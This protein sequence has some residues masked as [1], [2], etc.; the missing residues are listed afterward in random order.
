MTACSVAAFPAQVVPSIQDLLLDGVVDAEWNDAATFFTTTYSTSTCEPE[1]GYPLKI[2]VKHDNK[3]LYI[4]ILETRI[5]SW[6]PMA[7]MCFDVQDRN[8]LYSK[9]DDS[10]VLPI[11][12]GA[13][14]SDIDRGYYKDGL[15]P[16]RTAG[17]WQAYGSPPKKDTSLG[18]TNDKWG[19]AR[20]SENGYTFEM[21]IDMASGDHN[22][23]S[24]LQLHSGKSIS[25]SFGLMDNRLDSLIVSTI[26][27]KL[28]YLASK[29]T[30]LSIE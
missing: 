6:N 20:V 24:D 3:Y 17:P 27:P 18:G 11:T 8:K 4:A 19:A 12:G 7:W 22:H 28:L 21:K 9:G 1:H 5:L 13:I 2:L 30:D 29:K 16:A 14:L 23:G 25:V 10:V 26:T 15:L